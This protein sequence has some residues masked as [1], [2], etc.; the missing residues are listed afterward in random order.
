MSST[1]QINKAGKFVDA[2]HVNELRE[3]YR[4]E[5][6]VE[7]SNHLGKPDSL[8]VWYSLDELKEYLETAAA[9][10]AD[11][12]RVYFGAYPSTYPENIL[13]EG[14]QTVVFVATQQKQSDTGKTENK[15]L[16]VSTRKGPEVIAFNFGSICPPNCGSNGGKEKN[17][18]F[19]AKQS[20]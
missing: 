15:D 17:I 2:R 12:V 18:F 6:W 3:N 10:G 9:A 20:S 8:S 5:R 16:Y 7:N 14:R 4:T 19:L 1:K 13:L 11:G